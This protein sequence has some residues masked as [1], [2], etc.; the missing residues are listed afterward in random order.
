MPKWPH[1][2]V[3]ES[4]FFTYPDGLLTVKVKSQ[5]DGETKGG[6]FSIKIETRVLKPAKF[7]NQ[8]FNFQFVIGTDADPE[9]EE[10]ETWTQPPSVYAAGRYKSFLKACGVP[11]TGDTS[12]EGE[13]T[14]GNVLVIDVG[15]HE[16]DSGRIYNDTNIFYAEKGA[17]DSDA[18]PASAPSEKKRDKGDKPRE[19]AAKPAERR[20]P[21]K[22]EE[23]ETNGG[24]DWD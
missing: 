22:K 4:S 18:A 12:E 8:P 1:E 24:D 7:K 19:R 20:Q 21:P 23:D 10:A 6:K 15:H 5:E 11:F 9:A 2:E 3:P 13:N 17:P 14:P 16:D